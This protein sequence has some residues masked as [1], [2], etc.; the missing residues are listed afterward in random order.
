MSPL[1]AGQVANLWVLMTKTYGH[2]FVSNYG[3]ADDGT[4]A[5]GLAGITAEQLATGMARCIEQSAERCRKGH[6][7]WPPTLPEFRA[8]CLPA[9]RLTAAHDESRG[10]LPAP[11]VT[12]EVARE[13]MAKALAL[14]GIKR[15]GA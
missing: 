15:E 10:R 13:H 4:W 2:K 3:L 6:E 1:R 9:K 12:P 7:D 11:K 5:R 14:V 8:M